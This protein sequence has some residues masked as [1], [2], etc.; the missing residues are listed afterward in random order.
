MFFF[1]FL[2]AGLSKIYFSPIH[3][4]NKNKVPDYSMLGNTGLLI[5]IKNDPADS[6]PAPL[7]LNTT[8]DSVVDVFFLHPT[9]FGC[10]NRPRTW[11]ADIK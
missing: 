5:L 9:T 4:D 1:Y 8:K 10:Q 2:L 3:Q 7:E 11:N 6:V